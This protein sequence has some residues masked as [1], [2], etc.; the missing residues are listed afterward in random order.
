M[1]TGHARS[2]PSSSD[3]T[4][5]LS[6]RMTQAAKRRR[7][8][9]PDTS[10][11]GREE[12]PCTGTFQVDCVLIAHAVLRFF[13]FTCTFLS[14]VHPMTVLRRMLNVLWLCM[15]S[16][17]SDPH[18][19][20]RQRGSQDRNFRPYSH[21]DNN[22]EAIGGHIHHDLA[23][24]YHPWPSHS[25]PPRL[26]PVKAQRMHAEHAEQRE[27]SGGHSVCY[28]A[29]RSN[30]FKHSQK[31]GSDPPP[32]FL[33]RFAPQGRFDPEIPS[34]RD[35]NDTASAQHAQHTAR[36]STHRP[37][38]ERPG[39]GSDA[40]G[41]YSLPSPSPQ[42][43]RRPPA[44]LRML[45]PDSCGGRVLGKVSP[46]LYKSSSQLLQVP[47]TKFALKFCE[48]KTVTLVVNSL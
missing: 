17:N 36:S 4:V 16:R 46:L 21:P 18:W 34:S 42:S 24:E 30:D 29:R 27:Q 13:L 43:P 1:S 23:H 37:Q 5:S 44:V 48:S 25:Y 41:R 47:T 2:L 38:S 7:I 10:R 20:T 33:E 12:R 35:R 8:S 9:G 11:H 40:R 14:S 31:Q 26:A 28:I 22:G 6:R 19:S 32:R 15:Q 45:C 39:Y 3:V